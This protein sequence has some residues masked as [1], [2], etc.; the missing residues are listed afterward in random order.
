MITKSILKVVAIIT[1]TLVINYAEEAKVME[2]DFESGW[3]VSGTWNNILMR[4]DLKERK[5]ICSLKYSSDSAIQKK[6]IEMNINE[7]NEDVFRRAVVAFG[8]GGVFYNDKTDTNRIRVTIDSV[9]CL[10]VSDVSGYGAVNPTFRKI[11]GEI[12]KLIPE[13]ERMIKMEFIKKAHVGTDD[14]RVDGH[15]K[16]HPLFLLIQ[17]AIERDEEGKGKPAPSK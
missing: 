8:K 7:T 3:P 15:D 14:G 12:F 17:E 9:V 2:V 11:A 13:E 10:D 5:L 4:F 1:M 16:K 6:I